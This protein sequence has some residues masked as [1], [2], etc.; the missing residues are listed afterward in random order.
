MSKRQASEC[1]MSFDHNRRRV[2]TD[3]IALD[4]WHEPFVAGQD[5][6]GVFAEVS[7]SDG[8][9]GG[10]DEDFPL[11]FSVSLKRALLTI[12]LEHPL[13]I[14]RTSVARGIPANQSEYV[15]II[16]AKDAVRKHVGL[17]GEITPSLI[18][19]AIKGN[20]ARTSELT[21]EEELRI[22]REV[23]EILVTA[24][25]EG[26]R[27]YSWE[28]EPLMSKRLKGQ[29]WDPTVPPRM[30]II[31]PV[32]GANDAAIKIEIRCAL[33]DLHIY[34]IKPKNESLLD[35]IVT[36]GDRGIN[37]AVAIQHL[38]KILTDVDLYPG[39]MDNR[40]NSIILADV[41][42]SSS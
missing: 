40:F 37:E 12:K 33:E 36:M 25:P 24:R 31:S 26:P 11:T 34:D 18:G 9:I 21:K 4:A 20:V 29:P 39:K 27:S 42:A 7:F 30:Q 41:I 35:K 28:L 16:R 2:F 15:Q 8:R 10:D 22:T 17:A 5:R 14:D 38:K 6:I 23:P 3:V 19:A 13:V 1:P 32:N